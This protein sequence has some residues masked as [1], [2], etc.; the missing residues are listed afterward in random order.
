L[1]HWGGRLGLN[2]ITGKSDIHNKFAEI[3]GALK[4]S[5][6]KVKVEFEDHL[7]AINQNTNEIQGNYE[8]LCEIDNKINKLSERLDEI[9]MLLKQHNVIVEEEKPSFEV[10]ALSKKEKEVF[11]ALYTLEDDK[12]SVTYAD[13]SRRSALPVELLQ[14]YVTNL[15]E[16]G[17]PI[18]KRYINNIVY[19]K[20]DDRFRDAQTKENIVGLD[21]ELCGSIIKSI[22]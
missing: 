14:A 15:I 5:F 10:K 12:G 22:K 7:D 19:L 8:Y 9:T 17:V 3:E 20:L 18:V 13:M 6:G 1:I 11:L 4:S 21:D 16:K 2:I